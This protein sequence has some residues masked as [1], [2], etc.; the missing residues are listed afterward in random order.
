MFSMRS[1]LLGGLLLQAVTLAASSPSA[2]VELVYANG[3][4]RGTIST[5]IIADE[6]IKQI[7]AATQRRVTIRHVPG[8]ALLK[9][10]NMLE[11]VRNGVADIGSAVVPFFPGQ[12]PISATLAGTVDLVDGNKLT[13]KDSIAI[14]QKLLEEHSAFR[15]E[16]DRLNLRAAFWIAAAPYVVISAKRLEN[17]DD[18]KGLKIRT[19]GENMRKIIAATGAAPISMAFSEVYTSLQTGVIDAAVTDAPAMVTNRLYEVAKFVM[20]TGPRNGAQTAI[21]SIVFVFNKASWAKIPASDQA[22]IEQVSRKMLPEG[23]QRISDA[24][25]A[26]VKQLRERGVKISHLSEKETAELAARAGDFYSLAAEE[27]TKAGFPGN[28]ILQSYRTL[29][30]QSPGN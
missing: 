25:E 20:T 9:P 11:G 19:F 23:A 17:L 26:A 28:A 2:A 30:K 13:P 4:A 16:Y 24:Q 5:G 3:Y 27:I 14:V 22:I 1:F 12:L 10:E 8:G 18:F 6:W 21:P 7:E 29:V 15:D